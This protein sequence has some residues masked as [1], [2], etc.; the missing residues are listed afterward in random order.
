MPLLYFNCPSTGKPTPTEIDVPKD[1]SILDVQ[2]HS[3]HCTHCSEVH[4]WDGKD[5]FFEDGSK[6]SHAPEV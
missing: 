3:T 2:T 1:A 4:E 6:L 5:A